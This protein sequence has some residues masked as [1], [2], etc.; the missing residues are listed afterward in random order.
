MARPFF[1]WAGGKASS[2]KYLIKHVPEFDNYYEPFLGGGALF[3]SKTPKKAF[4]NDINPDLINA[5]KVVQQNVEPLIALLSTYDNNAVFYDKIRSSNPEEPIERAARFL[6]LN[7][8]CFNGLYR[9]NSKGQFN[10]PYGKNKSNPADPGTLRLASRVLQS[11]ELTNIHYKDALKNVGPNDF[12][13]LDPPYV[14]LSQTSFTRYTKGDFTMDDQEELLK[15]F[16]SLNSKGIK[17]M[18]SNSSA[19]WVRESYKD[20]NIIE[21]DVKRSI[22]SKGSGRGEI[23]ELLIKTW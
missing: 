6:Y 21:T 15:V 12:V 14:P 9:V 2:L 1:K 19:D 13:Y 18:L 22:N 17:A 16:K 3:F 10:V 4:L 8:T 20:F 23:K 11:A 5:Y 7:K